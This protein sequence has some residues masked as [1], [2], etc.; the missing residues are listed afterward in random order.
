MACPTLFSGERVHVVRLDRRHPEFAG[1]KGATTCKAR[2]P[3]DIKSL[4]LI[5]GPP[6]RG[7][8]C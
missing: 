8:L 6:V 5:W 3:G 7:T 4:V 2:L 1:A